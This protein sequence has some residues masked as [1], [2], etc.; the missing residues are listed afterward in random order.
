MTEQEKVL[1]DR[2][3]TAAMQ[4]LIPVINSDSEIRIFD[5]TDI[6]EEAYQIADAMLKARKL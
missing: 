5:P 6:C 1:R 4:A 3:A 2:F